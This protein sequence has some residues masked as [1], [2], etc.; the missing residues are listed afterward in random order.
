MMSG[1]GRTFETANGQPS[2][3]V[4]VTERGELKANPHNM[5][6]APVGNQVLGACG[7]CQWSILRSR[8]SGRPQAWPRPMSARASGD[9]VIVSLQALPTSLLLCINVPR[10]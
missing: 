7:K 1:P 9:T 8:E 2:N 3:V 4:S 6:P 5:Q 10:R